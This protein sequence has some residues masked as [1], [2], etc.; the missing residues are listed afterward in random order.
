VL[1]GV[2]LRWA[3]W[4]GLSCRCADAD[5]QRRARFQRA[6]FASVDLD[7]VGAL[8]A[9]LLFPLFL[10][11]KLGLVRTSLVFGLLNAGVG[12]GRRGLCDL[13]KRRGFGF[14]RARRD[15]NRLLAIGIIKANALTTLAEDELF[16]DE[17]FYSRTTLSANRYHPRPRRFPA[18]F[19]RAP[20]VQLD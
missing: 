10:V 16:A 11:P 13:D 19:E 14:A 2:V 1:Y 17:T 7:Y 15:C 18:V 5:P 6:G 20:A 4:S 3:C 9:S 12:C 8:I